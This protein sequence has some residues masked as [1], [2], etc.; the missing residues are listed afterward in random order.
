MDGVR[1]QIQIRRNDMKKVIA[2]TG[3]LS[4]GV[5]FSGAAKA[6]TAPHFFF[7]GYAETAHFLT[8]QGYGFGGEVGVQVSQLFSLVFEAATGTTTWDYDYRSD[9]STSHETIK[10]ALT[11]FIF[12]VHFTAPL[13]NHVQ[14]YVGVGIASWN[15]KLTDD[16]SYSYQSNSYPSST[17]STSKT[18]EFNSI[19]PIFKIG[20][21]VSLTPNVWII[22]EYRQIV[23]KDKLK[24][25]SDY[26]TSEGDLYFGS[27]DLKLG[28]RIVI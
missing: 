21:A 22:G 13:G 6:A 27:A 15:L 28:V 3:F 4:L 10:L 17:T 25:T 2:V 16:Y 11:P 8:Y 20:L 19:A 24:N 1:S 18:W 5:F 9:Y 7:G 26:S 14:P 23:A 12:S